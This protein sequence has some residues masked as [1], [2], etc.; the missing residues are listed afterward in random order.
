M[1]ASKFE[2]ATRAGFA[3]RG[4]LYLVI[5]FLALTAGRAEGAEGALEYLSSGT[6]RILLGLMAIGFLAYGIWRLSEALMDTEGHGDD[7]KGLAIRAGGFLSGLIHLGLAFYATRLAAGS[8]GGGGSRDGAEQGAATALALP[9]GQVLLTAAAIILLVTGLFQFAKAARQS[10]LRHLDHR[11]AKEA[12]VR[13]VGGL[14][15]A[16]RGIVFLIVAYLAWNAA[17][18]ESSEQAGGTG[19]AL[20][21][22]PPSLQAIVGAGFLLFGVFSL[23]EARY[24]RI[25]NPQVVERLA[26]KARAAGPETTPSRAQQEPPRVQ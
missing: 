13:W 26:A 23:V 12:W 20:Q 15:Y 5:G 17:Q 18:A 21:S 22:L 3:A 7:G 4:I 11:V 16:A 1:Q 2:A 14:G 6:G 9:G 8:A 24:R 25:N 19:E 10:F